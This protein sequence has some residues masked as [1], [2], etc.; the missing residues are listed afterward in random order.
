VAPLGLSGHYGLAVEGFV[1]AVEAGANLFFWEPNYQT[2]TSFAGRLS[3]ADRNALH[4]L[5]GTFEADGQRVCR[6]V[7]RALRLLGL[8]RLALYLLFWV[9]SWERVSD[10]VREALERLKAQ[11]K[12]GAFG[13]SSHSRRLAVQA[14]EAGWNPV[15]VRHSAAHRGAERDVFPCAASHGTSVITFSNTCY[16]RLLQPRP[17]LEPPSA[18]DCYRYTLEQPAVSA[19]FTAPATIELLEQNLAVLRDPSLP[20]DRRESLLAQGASLYK[21]E[22]IFRRLVRSR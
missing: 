8:D 20:A 11:G 13:L 19:C 2:L 22:T 21:E 15:M 3:A 1:L 12:I 4:F 14:I 10:D 7:E 5:S 17:G 9:Q 18:A 6:N 16:G